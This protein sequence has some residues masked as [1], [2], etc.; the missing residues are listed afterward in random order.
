MIGSDPTDIPAMKRWLSFLEGGLLPI[1]SL[2]SLH[3]FVKYEKVNSPKKEEDSPKEMTFDTDIQD[4]EEIDSPKKE[5]D[6]PKTHLQ[7]EAD[8]VWN[9]VKK[10]K[11][12]GVFTE[13]TEEEII[14]EP[15]ALAN[16]KYR[17][18]YEENIDDDIIESYMFPTTTYKVDKN[19][20]DGVRRLTYTK[21]S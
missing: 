16:S 4:I 9:T 13:P 6:S 21:P 14:N 19:E 20:D 2:T 7:K 15:T 10:L 11:E 12:E 1:I 3:F 17:E 8:R 18:Q 5:E